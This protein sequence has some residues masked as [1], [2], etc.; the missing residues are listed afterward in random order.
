MRSRNSLFS[1][2]PFVFIS[3]FAFLLFFLDAG[4]N[5]EASPLGSLVAAERNS[6]ISISSFFSALTSLPM[7]SQDKRWS[8]LSFVLLCCWKIF[9]H[10]LKGFRT[11]QPCSF[12]RFLR[13]FAASSSL[14]RFFRKSCT[15]AETP[16]IT[17]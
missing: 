14:S 11:V 15:R 10:L 13:S 1:S 17:F 7:V 8:P 12:S 3:C 5:Q 6:L 2:Y 16:S 9:Y 4:F